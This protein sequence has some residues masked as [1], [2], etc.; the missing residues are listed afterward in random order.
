MRRG[1][2]RT[3]LSMAWYP[4]TVLD[5]VHRNLFSAGDFLPG[6]HFAPEALPAL[7]PFA[8]RSEVDAFFD[9]GG[10][11][12]FSGLA[13]DFPDLRPRAPP[14]FSAKEVVGR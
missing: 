6:R 2:L 1:A 14:S 3:R 12:D 9:L 13:E 11:A 7:D 8:D 4:K 10:F 5:T